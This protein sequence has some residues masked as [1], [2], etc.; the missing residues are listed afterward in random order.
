M[1]T[2]VTVTLFVGAPQLSHGLT[3]PG[4]GLGFMVF[5]KLP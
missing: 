3:H 1:S 2:Y 5:I 4:A